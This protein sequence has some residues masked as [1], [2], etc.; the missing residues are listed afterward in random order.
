MSVPTAREAAQV[1]LSSFLVVPLIALSKELESLGRCDKRCSDAQALRVLARIIAARTRD[2][3]LM[4]E[5]RVFFRVVAPHGLCIAVRLDP[6]TEDSSFE[7]VHGRLE[8][9][10]ITGCQQFVKLHPVFDTG[11][12]RLSHHV[13]V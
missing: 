11:R 8:Q 5:T 2:P 10:R 12:I 7:L 13:E 6:R 1:L 9:Q 4:H 3:L